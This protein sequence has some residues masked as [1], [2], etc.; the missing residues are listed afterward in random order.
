LIGSQD[1]FKSD[2]RLPVS[3]C[4][5]IS[6]LPVLEK[7]M[8]NGM[9]GFVGKHAILSTCQF[10]FREHHLTSIINGAS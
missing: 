7:L 8:Y 1:I 9:I 10:G 6:V 4:R 5:P 3:N 2:D